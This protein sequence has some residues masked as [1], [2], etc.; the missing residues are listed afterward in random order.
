MKNA[1]MISIR[2]KWCELIASGEKTIDI[3]KNR[4]RL[5]T[6]FKCYIYCTQDELLTNC[7]GQIY[8]ATKEKYQ[9]ALVRNGNIIVTLSGKVIGEFVCDDIDYVRN[10]GDCVD[11]YD[12]E[13]S[14]L[15]AQEIIDYAKDKDGN[16]IYTFGWHI[17]GLK[18][19]DEPKELSAFGLKRPPQSWCY[20]EDYREEQA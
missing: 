16:F 8:L 17:S 2:P 1:V 13:A 19:Y 11:M 9:K 20:T 14:C 12:V 7:N 5:T 6:P 18:I 15:T 10:Y 4:P 3:R